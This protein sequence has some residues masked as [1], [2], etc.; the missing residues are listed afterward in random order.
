MYGQSSAVD[1]SGLMTMMIMICNLLYS[2]N[3]QINTI[4]ISQYLALN[5][6]SVLGRSLA[7]KVKRSTLTV[8]GT[9]I[10]DRLLGYF[11]SS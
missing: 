3:L 8:F 11:I 5:S 4:Y 7:I 6:I 10:A 2:N 1:Y 9:T